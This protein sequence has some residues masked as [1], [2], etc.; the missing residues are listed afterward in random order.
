[1]KKK[2]KQDRKKIKIWEKKRHDPSSSVK[3]T[4]IISNM[5]MFK[6]TDFEILACAMSF[7]IILCFI[8]ARG[9]NVVR[10]LFNR[11]ITIFR[12]FKNNIADGRNF[13]FFSNFEI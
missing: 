8:E 4:G 11:F 9:A 10:L 12:L 7:F 5:K 6:R 1:M 2:Q 13:A 3:V